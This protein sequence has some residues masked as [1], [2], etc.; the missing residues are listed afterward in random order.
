[1]A[2]KV[3]VGAIAAEELFKKQRHLLEARRR[4]PHL[5]ELVLARLR[6]RFFPNSL[7]RRRTSARVK[8]ASLASCTT[9]RWASAVASNS[10]RPERRRA[11]GSSPCSS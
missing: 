5:Y 4:H 6:Q 2:A 9:V 7:T 3:D 11:V 10:R 1:L 8:P